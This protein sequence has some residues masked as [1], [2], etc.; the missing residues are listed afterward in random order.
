MVERCG[1]FEEMLCQSSGKKQPKKGLLLPPVVWAHARTLSFSLWISSNVEI[2]HGAR[3]G[4][5]YSRLLEATLKCTYIQPSTSHIPFACAFHWAACMD[6]DFRER[7][8]FFGDGAKQQQL[9]A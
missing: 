2:P 8:E 4:T 5:R 7:S 6:D 1:T 9:K 3:G